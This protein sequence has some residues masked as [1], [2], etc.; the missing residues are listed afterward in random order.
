MYCMQ[1][2]HTLPAPPP[3]VVFLSIRMHHLLKLPLSERK[4]RRF[5]PS[6]VTGGTRDQ[7]AISLAEERW[8]RA[9]LVA[10]KVQGTIAAS[11][12]GSA[13]AD[14]EE[15]IL[16]SDLPRAPRAPRTPRAPRASHCFNVRPMSK[17]HTPPCR[18]ALQEELVSEYLSVVAER[19]PVPFH[20]HVPVY[21]MLDDLPMNC[22]TDFRFRTQDTLRRVMDCMKLPAHLGPF[23]NGSYCDREWGFIYFIRRMSSVDPVRA[24]MDTLGGNP[25]MWSRVFGWM[26][27]FI[28]DTMGWKLEARGL[29]FFQPRFAMYAE[30]IRNKANEKGRE[31]RAAGSA[32]LFPNP[33]DM[34][35]VGMLDGNFTGTNTPGTGPIA[36]GQAAPR[37]GNYDAIQLAFFTGWLHDHGIKHLNFDS[38]DGLTMFRYGPS[39][40]RHNDLGLLHDSNYENAMA[41]MENNA[42]LPLHMHHLGYGDSIFPWRPHLRSKHGASAADVNKAYKDDVDEAMSSVR[43]LIENHFAQADAL[44]PFMSY[45]RKLN[46]SNMNLGAMYTCKVIL[47]NMHVMVTENLTSD[48]MNVEPPELEDWA[49]YV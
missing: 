43:M 38:P 19:L 44:F 26:A 13:A 6:G 18:D 46:I 29:A 17:P 5:Y 1:H 48:R 32:D 24:L 37:R 12:A 30:A 25:P 35:V 34:L 16:V 41:A 31:I 3:Y 45:S 49:D 39:S 20:I 2:D 4:R 15:E 11:T 42:G 28:A 40:I 8:S 47:R 14:E 36:P 21:R 23:D 10:C 33:S 22:G 7:Q 27:E 9:L